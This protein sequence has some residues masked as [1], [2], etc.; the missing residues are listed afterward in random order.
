MRLYI[1]WYF[2]FVGTLR[3][4]TIFL[5]NYLLLNLFM[6]MLIFFFHIYFF[7]IK[8]VTKRVQQKIIQYFK[9]NDSTSHM[10]G[11][12]QHELN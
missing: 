9:S 11:E 1:I 3:L 4:C 6:L 8:L 7:F 2:F 12:S 10:S 5:L